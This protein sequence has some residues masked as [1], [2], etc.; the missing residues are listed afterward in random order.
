M[1]RTLGFYLFFNGAVILSLELAGLIRRFDSPAI[2]LLIQAG[3]LIIAFLV[4]NP[5]RWKAEV[6]ARL[7][8]KYYWKVIRSAPFLSLFVLALGG[9]YLF[10]AYLSFRFPQNTSDAL[11]NHLARIGYW[12][13]Q[14][15]LLPYAG[16][17]H[18]A[19]TYPYN[20]SLLM[21]WSIIFLRVDVLVE[22]VQYSATLI[23]ALTIFHFARKLGFSNKASLITGVV[24]L[25][26]PIVV[27]QSITA[28]ND[29]LAA[30]FGLL[31]IYFVYWSRE[32]PGYYLVSAVAL[33][34]AIGTKQYTLTL[35]PV[36]AVIGLI[37]LR[38]Y[39]ELRAALLGKWV[40]MAA[41]ATL[42]LGSYAY[43]QNLVN[44]Q[45]LFGHPPS[46]SVQSDGGTGRKIATNASRLAIHFIDGQGLPPQLEGKFN[47]A[48]ET[49]LRPLFSA[50][51]IDVEGENFLLEQDNPFSYSQKQQKNE[52]NS[53]F[54][55]LGWIV[56]ALSIVMVP[57]YMRGKE[58]IWLLL[59]AAALIH[60]LGIVVA[61]AGWNEYQ[62]R[63]LILS[64]ALILPITAGVF[65]LFNRNLIIRLLT[66]A[67]LLGGLMIAMISLVNNTSRPLISHLQME[68]TFKVWRERSY[69]QGRVIYALQPV[70]TNDNQVWDMTDDEV[71]T[72]G[73]RD[74]IPPFNLT[75]W[76]VP[77]EASLSIVGPPD[78]FPDYLFFGRH[79][80]R[81]LMPVVIEGNT[82]S[83][84]G[85]SEFVLI[86]PDVELINPSAEY[87]DD[88]D[89]WVLYRMK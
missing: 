89:H 83:D 40:G 84:V 34:L 43:V 8:L 50:L 10:L 62:G 86:P 63:Y 14:G 45:T 35:L 64:V 47:Q 32:E 78:Y 53:W 73:Y 5:K 16:F 19:S 60:F 23:A 15:S 30:A 11:Y 20:N 44:T 7:P 46:I 71:R 39:P 76:H 87:V 3:L 48:R 28:Q 74:A 25:T 69:W 75:Y 29:I 88:Y 55:P 1:D 13:Q 67:I 54:G 52:E 6:K 22:L 68:K 21:A 81:V 59:W 77:E 42:L 82:V 24:F 51:R 56:I 66:A 31:A 65:E 80:T 38:S 33:A 79:F 2:V 72:F 17:N 37:R 57:F 58:K 49:I 70:V 9:F 18:V 26:L 4:A 61:Y 41:V 12:L 36:Y 27:L 85:E